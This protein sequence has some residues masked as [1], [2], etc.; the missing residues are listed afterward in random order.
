MA[1]AIILAGFQP[2]PSPRTHTRYIAAECR[3]VRRKKPSQFGGPRLFKGG[4][5]VQNA[6]LTDLQ[7]DFRKRVVIDRRDYPTQQPGSKSQAL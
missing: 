5:C 3:V 2:K 7:S 4:N 1:A 6:K